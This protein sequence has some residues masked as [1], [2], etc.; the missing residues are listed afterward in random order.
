MKRILAVIL[1]A[2]LM[3]CL[4]SACE[5]KD[6]SSAN[7]TDIDGY[8]G[9]YQGFETETS[10]TDKNDNTTTNVTSKTTVSGSSNMNESSKTTST[11][12]N[13]SNAYVDTN[14]IKGEAYVSP[15]S[16]PDY[17]INV[18]NLREFEQ[19]N[20]CIKLVDEVTVNDYTTYVGELLANGF[21]KY[22]ET[23]MGQSQFTSL[24]NKTTFV[25]VAFTGEDN[26][27]KVI[28]EPLGDLYPRKQDNNYT[29]KN[30]QSL[31][32][33]LKNQNRPIYS[34]MGFI[35]RL[36][37]GRFIIIDGGGGDYN[38][39]D[40]NN[41]LKV[42][43]EQAPKGTEKP[44]IAAWIFTHAHNDHIGA[45]NAFTIDFKDKVII[46]S[47]YYNFPPVKVIRDKTTNFSH[48]EYYSQTSFLDCVQK[49]PGAKFIRP[50]AGEKI[51]I[52][53]AVIDVLFSYEHLF[54]F[55]LEDGTI[56]DF[57]ATSLIFKIN[58]GGQSMLI[59]GDATNDAMYFVQN[60]FGSFAQ[61][62]LLQMSHHGQFGSRNFYSLVNPTYAILPLSH[63][64]TNRMSKIDANRWLASS[65]KL[66]QVITFWGSNVTIPLPYNPTDAQIN[67][68]IPNEHTIYHNYPLH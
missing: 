62:E 27:L 37:D 17:N 20:R 40:S 45:F 31:F 39:I 30:M 15:Y 25:S 57:N 67:D 33:G 52:G 22:D 44:V 13:S 38:H 8:E 68:R 18:E 1:S 9:Q 11:S 55:N 6:T 48:D 21:S 19:E 5:N 60:N 26:V 66:R 50:H 7:N 53:N 14:D 64:D 24:T 28:S 46:E 51:Y 10:Q 61:S 12:N 54:P 29:E 49:Y 32:T 2:V 63:V 23:K 43:K 36:S 59:T 58:I 3:V 34:G 4:F 65:S 47:F 35:I 56:G 41:M 16:L 42:L